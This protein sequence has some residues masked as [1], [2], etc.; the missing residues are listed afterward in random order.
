MNYQIITDTEALQEFINWLPDLEPT[1]QFYLC[2]FARSKYTKDAEGT[3]GI[4]HIKSDKAQ[5]RRFTS[6]KERLYEKISQ[7]ECPIGS[8]KQRDLIIP[9][10]ALAIY[11]S[12][13]P[14]DLWKATKSSL[15]HFATMVANNSTLNNPHQEAMSEI[16]K[17]PGKKHYR[18]FDLDSKDPELLHKALLH[19]SAGSYQIIETRGGYHILVKPQLIGKDKVSTWY[20]GITSS[21]G[22]DAGE[23]NSDIMTPIPGTYQGGFTPKLL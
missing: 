13:N 15:V 16:Q 6:T 9:Q 14:R 8:Y 10:E 11:I 19:L 12:I 2:L 5:L 18:I 3:N 7:L 1:E 20:K 22:I 4:P 17:S 21:E 23:T